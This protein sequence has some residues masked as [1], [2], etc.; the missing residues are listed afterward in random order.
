M[1]YAATMELVCT[2]LLSMES[3]PLLVDSLH[4]A[5]PK[6]LELAVQVFCWNC[7]LCCAYIIHVYS[8]SHANI[9]PSCMST[10]IDCVQAHVQQS[11]LCTH[12]I[13]HTFADAGTGADNT[14][15]PSN[16]PTMRAPSMI[17]TTSKPTAACIISTQTCIIGGETPCCAGTTCVKQ[18]KR[19]ICKLG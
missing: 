18:G 10:A 3:P 9:H 4:Q 1:E 12:W 13:S 8:F 6:H 17:P 16:A 2:Q 5:N 11:N 7:V 19:N 15:A 14:I